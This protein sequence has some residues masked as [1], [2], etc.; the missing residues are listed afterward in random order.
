MSPKERLTVEGSSES[1][2]VQGSFS[3]IVY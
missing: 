2:G 1:G 3:A